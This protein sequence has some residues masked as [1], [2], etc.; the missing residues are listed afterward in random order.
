MSDAKESR[1]KNHLGC[2]LQRIKGVWSCHNVQ[3]LETA[4]TV[5]GTVWEP[6]EL[7]LTVSD[8]VLFGASVVT[9]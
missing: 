9:Q 7:I 5:E 4:A 2:E 6:G 8:E 3:T 1:T